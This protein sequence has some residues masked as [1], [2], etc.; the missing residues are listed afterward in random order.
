[1]Q[2][3]RFAIVG[4]AATVTHIAVATAILVIVPAVHPVAANLTAFLAALPVSFIGHSRFTFG[5]RGSLPKYLM[6]VATGVSAN[7]LAL[8]CLLLGGVPEIA[9][10]CAAALT[11]SLVVYRAAKTWAFARNA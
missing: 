2:V 1:M 9:A 3:V 4:A 10:V 5:T 11:G 8:V 7:N 6:T